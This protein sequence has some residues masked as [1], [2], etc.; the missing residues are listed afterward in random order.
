MEI[1]CTCADKTRSRPRGRSPSGR[2]PRGSRWFPLFAGR[3]RLRSVEP[4]SRGPRLSGRL[5]HHVR[6]G[7]DCG[8][9]RD[10]ESVRPVRGLPR[11]RWQA[12]PRLRLAGDL[13]RRRPSSSGLASGIAFHFGF[14]FRFA[15]FLC[16]S[17][18][19]ASPRIMAWISQVLV[20]I[21]HG[22]GDRAGLGRVFQVF[23]F[24]RADDF[25]RQGRRCLREPVGLQSDGSE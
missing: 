22:R 25:F 20:L 14:G 9:K 18:T 15:R 2:G 8:A 3:G 17:S 16:R 6:R 23:R 10:A 19:I 13:Q 1:C 4:C 11:C 24:L 7:G 12:R 5:L 21:E